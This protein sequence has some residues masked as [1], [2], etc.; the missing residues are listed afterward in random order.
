MIVF[1][2]DVLNGIIH[3]QACATLITSASQENVSV[4]GL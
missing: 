3:R 1:P 4:E 2:E